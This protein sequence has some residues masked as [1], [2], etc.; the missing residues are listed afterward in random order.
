MAAPSRDGW[1]GPSYEYR[2]TLVSETHIPAISASEMLTK[3]GQ[4]GFRYVGSVSLGDGTALLI[5]T[6]TAV[7]VK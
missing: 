5:P 1:R 4:Q 6:P 7:I 3:M 2:A